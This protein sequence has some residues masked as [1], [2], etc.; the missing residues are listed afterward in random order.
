M[1]P[2]LSATI[3]TLITPFLPTPAEGI[4]G[5]GQGGTVWSRERLLGIGQECVGETLA[6]GATEAAF[7]SSSGGLVSDARG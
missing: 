2:A 7:E 5:S 6:E 4:R 3:T 1:E